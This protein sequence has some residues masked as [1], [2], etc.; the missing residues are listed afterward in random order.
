MSIYG[1]CFSIEDEREWIADLQAEGIDAGV[2]RDGA[3]SPEDLDAP[4]VYRGSH[5]L[6][7]SGDPR[8]GSIDLADIAAHVRFWRENPDAPI[9]SEPES[10]RE[11]FLR[12]SVHESKLTPNRSEGDGCV[13]LTVEQAARLRDALTEWITR[14]VATAERSHQALRP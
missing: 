4:Y 3:P 12:F 2:I 5:I 14:A 6:P 10:G 1:T 11:P 13:L 7:E 8:G 9:D